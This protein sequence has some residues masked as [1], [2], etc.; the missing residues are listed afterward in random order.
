MA[1]TYR[2]VKGSALTK[3]EFDENFSFLDG[4]LTAVENDPPEAIGID[5][6]VIEGS[7]FT[8]VMTDA[9]EHGPFVLPVAQWRFTGEWLVSTTYFVGDLFKFEGSL[10]FVRVQHV[11]DDT[12][13]DPALFT[14]DGFVYSLL[15]PR[16]EFALNINFWYAP[17]IDEGED[18][19]FQYV[20]DRDF[21][22]AANF[23]DAQCYLRVAASARTINLPVYLNAA[24][25]GAI[26]FVPG[27]TTDGNG[28][29]FGVFIASTPDTDL[30]FVAGDVIAVGTPYSGDST[31]TGLSVSIPAVVA[32]I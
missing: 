22:I 26:R 30:E 8:V 11:S 13:F 12:E 29:Q 21:T 7:L 6:F 4:R 19:I 14:V 23:E 9:S 15:L 25:I 28:G 1:I 2:L 31:A 16:A 10:Y 18:I 17:L 5:H 20:C 3:A 27:V 32:G 24:V